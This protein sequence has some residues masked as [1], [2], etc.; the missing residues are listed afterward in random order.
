MVWL[1]RKQ[2]VCDTVCRV[3]PLVLRGSGKKRF[4]SNVRKKQA[5][6][7]LCQIFESIDFCGFT[8]E[9]FIICSQ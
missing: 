1:A 2:C 4:L 7:N 3:F 6:L 8:A 9:G 5:S